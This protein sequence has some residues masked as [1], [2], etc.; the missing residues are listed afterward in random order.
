MKTV[1]IIGI[2][3]G[4]ETVTAQGA[5]A[6]GAADVLLGAPRMTETFADLQKPCIPEYAAERVAAAVRESGAERFAVLVSGDVGFYSAAESLLRALDFCEVALVPGISSLGYFFAKLRLP[7]QD[8]AAISC[9]GREQNLVDTVRRSRRTFALT[10]GNIPALAQALVKAGYGALTAT[11]GENLGGAQ[12]RIFSRPVCELAQT[13]AA[14]LAVLL[15]ENPQADASVPCGIA[16]ERFV[17]GDVPMTKA[18]VRAAIAGKLRIAP[19]FV[20]A[21]VGAGTGSVTA[22]MALAAWRGHVYA[23]DRVP[24]A[25]ELIE[26]N[27]RRFHLG[28]VTP[29]LGRAPEA[30]ETLPPLDAV[31]IGGSGGGIGAIVSAV[32]QKN[33]N[34]RIVA[35]AIA[36]ESAAAAVRA[37]SEAGLE[38]EVV[39]IAASR[40]RTVAGL[41]MMMAL[42]PIFLISGGG[43]TCPTES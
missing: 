43:K 28:N 13:S 42:N 26:Q 27:A 6:I 20:C 16:D 40:S 33:P 1:T 34:A 25:V 4:R 39:Q 41:H 11:V 21:D 35:S 24:E 32:L 19:D 2:G 38:P 23:I 5:D 7:W 8:A 10:G 29:I 12:E 30:L 9:H 37:F 14:S 36:L 18:E 3:M 15:I 17:R 22:E 31:F